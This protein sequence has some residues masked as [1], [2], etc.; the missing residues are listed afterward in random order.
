MK[1]ARFRFMTSEN[2]KFFIL[3]AGG[4]GLAVAAAW[5]ISL[6]SESP[7]LDSVPVTGTGSLHSQ[8]SSSA[9]SQA[10][11]HAAGEDAALARWR[12]L[13]DAEKEQ[14]M[15]DHKVKATEAE[16]A[17]L[18]LRALAD[19]STDVRKAAVFSTRHIHSAEVM[20][21]L[22]TAFEDANDEIRVQALHEVR[23]K[24]LALKLSLLETALAATNSDL[25]VGALVELS[26]LNP[27]V[28]TPVM[29]KGLDSADEAFRTQ[30]WNE[31]LPNVRVLRTQPFTST[32][33]ALAWWEVNAH[34]YDDNMVVLDPG[35]APAA[36]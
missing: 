5:F 26:R 30:V 32:L 28:A 35:G 18:A 34:R 14:M 4:V 33:D 36:N 10:A 17:G 7:R 11:T 29:M 12:T 1:E 22:R 2:N 6:P 19:A 16:V 13:T 3:T 24:P 23:Y 25:R 21:V 31:L 9:P 20:P 8:E 27:K 15:E